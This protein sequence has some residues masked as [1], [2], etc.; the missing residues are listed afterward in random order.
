MNN[1]ITNTNIKN[2]TILLTFFA[3]QS[4]ICPKTDFLNFL[5]NIKKIIAKIINTMIAVKK[6]S[7]GIKNN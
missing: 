6:I 3:I 7:F 2:I 4:N 1:N 5:E